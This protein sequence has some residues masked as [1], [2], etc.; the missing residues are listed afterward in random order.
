MKARVSRHVKIEV[1]HAT[2]NLPTYYS[3]QL[4]SWV[5]ENLINNAVDAMSGK[6]SLTVTLRKES[7][8]AI[9]EVKDTGAGIKKNHYKTIFKTGFTSKK[10]GWGLGLA[11]AKRIVEEYHK[12]SIFVK[13]SEEGKG[14]I[15]R[16]EMNIDQ[17]DNNTRHKSLTP[18]N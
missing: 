5:I 11:L 4:L 15:I 2:E 18:I 9:I 16:V 13:N 10:R 7:K 17:K 1:K 12:G 8:K 14:T 6:G 3:K